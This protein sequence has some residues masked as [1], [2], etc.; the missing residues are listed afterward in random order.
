[1]EDELFNAC[2][3][4]LSSPPSKPALLPQL[5]A[6]ISGGLITTVALPSSLIPQLVEEGM[7]KDLANAYLYSAVPACLFGGLLSAW[8]GRRKMVLLALGYIA[9]PLSPSFAWLVP[10]RVFTALGAWLA[11]PSANVLVTEFVHPTVRGSL[12]SF[13][14]LFLAIGMLQSYALGYFLPWRTMAFVLAYQPPLLLLCLLLLPE[15]PQWLALQGRQ[16]E[17]SASLS[18]ARGTEFL[19]VADKKNI[20]TH[21]SRSHLAPW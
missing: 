12:G 7:A 2:Q 20:Q 19:N 1:M 4:L 21:C 15:S 5:L 11:Y 8:L 3:P 6:A 17:A 9:L 13:T 14:S 10:A 18:W 16:E